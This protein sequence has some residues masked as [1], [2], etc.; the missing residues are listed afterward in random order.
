[1]TI[2]LILDGQ[3]VDIE[4][5]QSVLDVINS[6]GTYIPQLCKDPDM[7][8]IGACRTCIVEIEGVRGMPASCSTPAIN[9][10]VVDT[11]SSG[12]ERIRKGILDLTLGM[13][14]DDIDL[15]QLKQASDKYGLSSTTWR[16]EIGRNLILATQSLILVWTPAYCALDALMLVKTHISLL[17]R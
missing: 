4:E 13:V 16:L 8:P 14:Q 2:H 1:M 7:K 15:G 17:V 10:M 5:G 12:V 9:G 6:S 11:N 3:K